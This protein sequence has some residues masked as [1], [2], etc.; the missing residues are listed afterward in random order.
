VH[1]AL[2]ESAPEIVAEFKRVGFIAVEGV[3]GF[4]DA[5]QQFL[6]TARQF[7]DLSKEERTQCTGA[8]YAARGWSRGVEVF[9][10]KTDTY[11]GSYYAV[12]PDNSSNIWPEEGLPELRNAYQNVATIV[13]EAG[14]QILPIV[15][16][17]HENVKGLG[18]MLHYK[19]VAGGEDD[20]NANWC[21]DH[22]DHGVFTCL[23]SE[24][25]YKDGEVVSRPANS[26]L[27]I[28]GN[29]VGIPLDV[30]ISRNIVFFQMGEVIELMTK[31]EV[32]ATN[33]LV[34]KATDGSERYA[35]AVFVDPMD[36]IIINFGGSSTAIIEKYKDRLTEEEIV[37]G[38]VTFD[39]W[40]AR[41]L[42]KYNPVELAPTTA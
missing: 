17:S 19:S 41:S 29:P 37:S 33:H 42:A 31:G 25:F 22:R 5:Y 26:G 27:Y 36:E 24:A 2:T 21:G 12:V 16:F 20:G 6:A 32:R 38:S 18:R 9:N 3:P 10:G 28:E 23:C 35:L 11:K 7:T 1:Y 14:K 34:K 39:A 15:G 40:N 8:T 13:L 4:G 30:A